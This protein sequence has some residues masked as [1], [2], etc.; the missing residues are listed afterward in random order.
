MDVFSFYNQYKF[1]HVHFPF[2]FPFGFP[3]GFPLGSPLAQCTFSTRS[4]FGFPFGFPLGLPLGLGE[5]QARGRGWSGL[6][7]R[8]ENLLFEMSVGG[9]AMVLGA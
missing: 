7:K 9:V 3:L 8:M 4:S 5:R 2:G 6:G 1:S